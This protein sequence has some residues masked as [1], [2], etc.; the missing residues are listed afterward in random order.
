MEGYAKD[1]YKSFAR[2]LMLLELHNHTYTHINTLTKTG[3]RA[4]MHGNYQG[5][6][7]QWFCAQ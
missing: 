4:V 1:L 2:R 5:E 3:S 6:K 7:D